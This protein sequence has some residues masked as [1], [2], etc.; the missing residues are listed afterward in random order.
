MTFD[1][2]ELNKKKS[3][4]EEAIRK[5][6]NDLC[7]YCKDIDFEPD[8]YI[9][10]IDISAR[11]IMMIGSKYPVDFF[12]DVSLAQHVENDLDNKMEFDYARKDV[13]D[14]SDTDLIH[15]A[16]K[17]WADGYAH[18]SDTK[19]ELMQK[20]LLFDNYSYYDSEVRKRG[21]SNSPLV[22]GYPQG[23][24]RIISNS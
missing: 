13:S 14:M 9:F 6:L 10:D 5:A 8:I 7:L 20:H 19:N 23:Y 2:K 17:A 12:V 16:V 22:R 4:C 1:Q 15:L 3:E 11:M 24:T 18:P 21:W